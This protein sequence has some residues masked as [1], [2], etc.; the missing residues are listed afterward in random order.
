[1]TEPGL[2]ASP[3][4]HAPVSV[5]AVMRDVLLGLIP[6]LLVHAWYFGPGIFVQCMLAAA[7]AL[8]CEYGMLRLR[9]RP[10]RIFL[11]DGSALVTALLLALTLSPFTPWW[12]TILG[13]A[14]AIVVAK[15][16]YGGLGHNLF[17]PAMAGYVF[18][19][20]CFPAALTVWPQPLGVAEARLGLTDTLAMI[21]TGAPAG[22]TI[23][24]LTGATPIGYLRTQLAQ[25][26]MISELRAHPLFGSVG[27]RGFETLAFAF[28]L[29]GAWLLYR[30]VIQ[31]RIPASLIGG[32]FA[33]SL[34]FYAIDADRYASPVFHLFSGGTMLAAFFIAT[35]PVSAATTPRGRLIFGA[36]IGVL[37]YLIRTFGGY[38][39]GIAFAVLLMNAAAPLIDHYTRPAV[40]GEKRP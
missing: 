19:L 15:H 33:A 17:N 35:D 24:S 10:V 13:A 5:A 25:M 1:M 29:G 32:L 26:A 28:L 6:G 2:R 30:R 27:G 4:I 37:A 11:Y 14:F 34:L 31:W 38:P 16:L 23:D 20:L 12:A 39:D 40:L 8:A 3:H 22:G 21:F 18:V 7:T 36:S 9:G